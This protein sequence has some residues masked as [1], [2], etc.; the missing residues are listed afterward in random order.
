MATPL[1]GAASA[2]GSWGYSRTRSPSPPPH[3]YSER[4]VDFLDNPSTPALV[5]NG[6]TLSLS[7]SLPRKGL[8]RGARSVCVVKRGGAAG[9]R[10][11]DGD[12]SRDVCVSDVGAEP[13][14]HLERLL[15]CVYVPLLA[16]PANAPRGL[17]VEEMRDVA[18]S[19]HALLA[20]A[21]IMAS[22]TRGETTLPMPPLDETTLTFSTPKHVLQLLEDAVQT[23][24]L[25]IGAVLKAE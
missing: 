25:Q 9:G 8:P 21:A 13:L 6:D 17:G 22:A 16:H 2:F 12:P 7:T 11:G 23:W 20:R 24:T 1:C 18:H 14:E 3:L 10:V 19:L 5:L 15:R 4:L